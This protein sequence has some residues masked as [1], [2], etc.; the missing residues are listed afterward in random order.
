MTTSTIQRNH[1]AAFRQKLDDLR[2]RTDGHNVPFFEAME[3]VLT[4]ASYQDDTL[5]RA[6]LEEANTALVASVEQAVEDVTVLSSSLRQLVQNFTSDLEGAV[7][8]PDEQFDELGRLISRIVTGA[9]QA[10][11][12]LRD[13][14]VATMSKHGVEVLNAAKLDEH[15][16]YWE[17]VKADLV[18]LWPWST[19][20]VPLPP[21]DREMIA[22]SRAL[23]EAG[24]WG[25][26]IDALIAR[27]RSE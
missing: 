17:Q 26:D 7:V 10:V 9:L 20:P 15:I 23:I 4:A 22:R 11:R 13:G 21:A 5:M 3:K 12:E 18:D 1:L 14:A 27:L 6:A 2:F 24:E 16:A 8:E 19:G 25:E